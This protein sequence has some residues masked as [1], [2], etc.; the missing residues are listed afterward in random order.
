EHTRPGESHLALRRARRRNTAR[1]LYDAG[2]SPLHHNTDAWGY[3]DPVDGDVRWAIWPVGGLWL[4]WQ[5]DDIASFSGADPAETARHRFAPRR[6]AAAPA[7]DLLGEDADGHLVTFPST[8]PEN[9][10][11]TAD[12]T[13]V[14]L[15]EGT[16][17][18][19]WLVRETLRRLIEAAD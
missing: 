13:G 3:T 1:R 5:L 14:A 17:M 16:G 9:R 11:L 7:L 4:G 18:D 6:E 2:G 12:G 19:R 15:S 8:S 10:W